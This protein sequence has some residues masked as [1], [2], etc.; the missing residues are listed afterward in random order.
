M[1]CF[2]S[3][4]IKR[5]RYTYLCMRWKESFSRECFCENKNFGACECVFV[6]FKNVEKNFIANNK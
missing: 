3:T 5:Y 1:G 6:Q 4:V 2:M